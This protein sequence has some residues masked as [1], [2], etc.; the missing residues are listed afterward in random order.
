MP[1]DGYVKYQTSCDCVV[2][3]I[4]YQKTTPFEMAC[5]K[6]AIQD[7]LT[8]HFSLNDTLGIYAYNYAMLVGMD[9][10]TEDDVD[11]AERFGLVDK[12]EMVCQKNPDLN[13]SD[14]FRDIMNDFLLRKIEA[15]NSISKLKKWGVTGGWLNAQNFTY[16]RW[17]DLNY[18]LADLL[19]LGCTTENVV[20]MDPLASKWGTQDISDL[21]DHP[22]FLQNTEYYH[23]HQ[24]RVADLV[25]GSH[26]GTSSSGSVVVVGSTTAKKINTGHAAYSAPVNSPVGSVGFAAGKRMVVSPL[27]S[28]KPAIVMSNVPRR[29]QVG[30]SNPKIQNVRPTSSLIQEQTA[31]E[32][33]SGGEDGDNTEGSTGKLQKSASRGSGRAR[34]GTSSSKTK[35]SS[36]P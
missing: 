27:G 3:L 6:C 17:R 5:P 31:T 20:L 22:I 21:H 35:S 25:S 19:D 2:H 10:Q 24:N 8:S 14:A 4:C 32:S 11:N 23:Q 33:I 13:P 36:R 12:L 28:E 1:K 9:S 7:P 34:S 26:R 18:T 30:V 16:G 29:L 15:C